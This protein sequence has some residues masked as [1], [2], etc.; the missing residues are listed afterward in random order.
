MTQQEPLVQTPRPLPLHMALQTLLWISSAAAL[1]SLKNGSLPWNPNLRKAG[2]ALA[3]S[4]QKVDPEHFRNALETEAKRRLNAFTKGIDA[5][6]RQ[7]RNASPLPPPVVWSEG[8]VRLYDYGETA[9][10]AK[11]GAPLLIVPSLVNRATILDLSKNKSLLRFLATKGF[12]PFLVDWGTPGEAERCYGLDE[13]ILGPLQGALEAAVTISGRPAVLIGYCMGGLLA[14]ASAIRNPQRTAAFCALATPWDFHAGEGAQTRLLRAMA[15]QFELLLDTL[16]V[17]PVDILQAFFT[18]LSPF[19]SGDKFRRFAAMDKRTTRARDFAALEDWIN[20]GVPLAGP[21][22][23]DCLFGWY[24]ENKPHEGRWRVGGRCVRPGDL[25]VPSL[26]V[27][28]ERDHIV[29]PASARALAASTP[30]SE[31]LSPHAGHIGMVAGSTST[32]ALFE[33][34]SQWLE[35]VSG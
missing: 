35:T 4:L 29:P 17:L 7:P 11:N 28:P 27:L 15:P 2:A 10:G 19:A 13:Y 8:P 30:G 34:L 33:P 12:R 22:A 3:E 20:D 23:K 5:Y 31:I 14:L 18:G 16:G 6:H 1:P 32:T 25:K 9:N 24:M 26:I 21:V